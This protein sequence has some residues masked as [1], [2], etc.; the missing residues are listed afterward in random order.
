LRELLGHSEGNPERR[1]GERRA[2]YPEQSAE[3]P[4]DA[5]EKNENERVQRP[6]P[7]VNMLA[8]F[9]A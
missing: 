6:V 4:K 8:V 9:C 1:Y 5:A 7:G 3:E 2:A